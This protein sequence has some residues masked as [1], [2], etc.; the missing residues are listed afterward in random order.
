M[1]NNISKEQLKSII[2]RIENLE[3]EKKAISDDIKD[4][5]A[6]AKG[7][8]YNTAIIRQVVK[9]RKLDAQERQQA[10]AELELYM[11]TLGMQS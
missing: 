1:T 10:E 9:L 2:S 8:G 7:N 5:Y 11:E 4:V 6:E 3:L